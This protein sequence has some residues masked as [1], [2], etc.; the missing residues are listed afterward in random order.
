MSKFD[1][2]PEAYKKKLLLLLKELFSIDKLTSKT[3]HQILRKYP[4]SKTSLFAKSEVIAGLRAFYPQKAL[5]F[6]TKL[7]MKPIRTSSGVVPVTLLTKPHP[8]PGKCIFCPN[9]VKM[10]K[11]YLSAEPGAQRAAG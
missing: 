6:T 4:K 5:K 7:Q 2:N 10:P 3:Y 11:S 9:D 8:C 1:F